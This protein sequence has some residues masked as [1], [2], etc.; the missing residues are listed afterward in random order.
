V[1]ATAEVGEVTIDRFLGG[2]VEAVQPGRGH[3]RSGLEAVLLGAS[4]SSDAAGTL[5]DLGAGVGVAGLC[6]AAR[7]PALRVVLAER[8]AELAAL[9]ERA[10]ALPANAGIHGRVVTAVVDVTAPE[11]DR[12][13]AG[14]ARE[15]ADIVVTNPPFDLA[16]SGTASPETG[17]R[18]AHVLEGGFEAWL[19]AAAWLLGPGGTLILIA[20]ASTLPELLRAAEGRFGDL[21]VLPIHPRPA[22]PAERVI[23]RGAK[24]RAGPLKLLPGLVLHGPTGSQF[25][26][27]L[28]AILRN[29]AGLADI[30]ETWQG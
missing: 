19:R 29:G 9:A 30:H 2:R 7:S 21:A 13:A 20:R 17:R 4:V 18:R 14:L 23:L 24:G 3:H 10:L 8:E 27:P 6:A 26:P 15:A 16:G 5:I 12:L 1:D 28:E 11:R 25:A 22:L